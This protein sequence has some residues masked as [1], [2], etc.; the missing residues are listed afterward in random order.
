MCLYQLHT[1]N[2]IIPYCKH[3]NKT[4][5]EKILQ[6]SKRWISLSQKVAMRKK[7]INRSQRHWE[8]EMKG[9]RWIWKKKREESGLLLL[10]AVG[11]LI[12]GTEDT[13]VKR[14]KSRSWG[15][16]RILPLHVGCKMSMRLSQENVWGNWEDALIR[17]KDSKLRTYKWQQSEFSVDVL[18]R[19]TVKQIK[20]NRVIHKNTLKGQRKWERETQRAA[21]TQT[22]KPAEHSGPSPG[23]ICRCM[24]FSFH[25]LKFTGRTSQCQWDGIKK[26]SVWEVAAYIVEPSQWDYDPY[27]GPEQPVSSSSQLPVTSG[28][29]KQV[30]IRTPGSSCSPDTEQASNCAWKFPPCL[31]IQ[32]SIF[33]TAIRPDMR[34]RQFK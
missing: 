27:K 15:R 5:L 13:G 10:S 20:M 24:D 19:T 3:S 28:H 11:W 32:S 1:M 14:R 2:I 9:P 16:W 30:V 12:T 33:V 23:Y 21:G 4:K 34:V 17:C 22:E 25:A 29:S 26:Q 7:N 6:I 31:S 18:W 8:V